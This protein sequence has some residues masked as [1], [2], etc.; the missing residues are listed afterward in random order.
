MKILL[1]KCDDRY[2]VWKEATLDKAADYYVCDGDEKKRKINPLNII[3]TKDDE[4]IGY[5]KCAN[6]GELIKNNPESIS[7]HY[8]EREAQQNC[9]KCANLRTSNKAILE[10]VGNKNENGEYTVTQ[11]YTADLL[12][13]TGYFHTSIDDP[14]TTQKCIYH[15]CRSAGVVPIDDIFVKYPDVF[16]KFVTVDAL[17]NKKCEQ[18]GYG[19]GFFEYDMKCRGTLVARVNEMG[20]VD[21]FVLRYRG[22]SLRLYYSNK[23]NLLF[24]EGYMNYSETIPYYIPEKKW[25]QVKTKI[26]ELYKE[27]TK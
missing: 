19:N 13:G 11:T 27:A 18:S 22:A 1:R 9:F 10:A 5:V 8:D 17:L 7:A 12:C 20:I 21:H 4:R 16:D 26:A 15:K 23:Y 6:C 2:Y 25:E 14:N 24:A 3:A